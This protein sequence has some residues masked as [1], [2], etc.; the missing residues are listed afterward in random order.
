M[1]ETNLWELLN[2]DSPTYTGGATDDSIVLTIGNYLPDGALSPVHEI[3]AGGE[4]LEHFPVYVAVGPIIGD[5]MALLANRIKLP[6]FGQPV[7][8]FGHVSVAYRSSQKTGNHVISKS[9][10]TP[11]TGNGYEPLPEN[12]KKIRPGYL[13]L[14][15]VH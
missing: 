5:H 9:K 12:G 15:L 13:H 11:N 7:Q 10:I 6:H 3:G 2:P 1:N 14:Q 8:A 4:S